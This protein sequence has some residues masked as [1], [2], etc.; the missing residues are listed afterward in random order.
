MAN[1]CAWPLGTMARE[2]TSVLQDGGSGSETFTKTKTACPASQVTSWHSE[3]GSVGLSGFSECSHS[4][5]AG[6]QTCKAE[7]KY[8]RPVQNPTGKSDGWIV[9]AVNCVI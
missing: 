1:L 2:K 4:L 6:Y 7:V 9:P 5:R 3:Y 8:A